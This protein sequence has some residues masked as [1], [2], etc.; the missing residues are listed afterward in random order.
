M[1]SKNL[2]AIAVRASAQAL[3]VPDRRGLAQVSKWLGA[4]YPTLAGWAVDMG[5]PGGVNWLNSVSG[6]PTR[7]FSDPDCAGAEDISGERMHATILVERD[8]CNV[9][10]ITCKQV[11]CI[12]DGP[13]KVDPQYGGPEYE[14]LAAFGANCGISDLAAVAKANEMACAY[15]LDTISTGATLAFVMECFEAGLLTPRQTG[16]WALRFGDAPGMVRA[17]EMIGRR[18]GFGAE[19]GQGSARLGA[20]AGWQVSVDEIMTIVRRAATL[21]RVFNHREGLDPASERL[22]K[23]FFQQF[24]RGG[25]A[26][27]RLDPAALDHAKRAY[28]VRLGWAPDAGQPTPE[29]LAALDLAW[30]TEPAEH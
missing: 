18:T 3:G 4:N 25:L 30:T 5:M 27:E 7:N 9:C 8:T 15:G 21:G 24:A 19:M 13:Y 16:G 10:P 12:D 17:I 29:T 11:V 22:P 6:L 1:G 28:F 14:T 26:D 20:A 23:R 2:K